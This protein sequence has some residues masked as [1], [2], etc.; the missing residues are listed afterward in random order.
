[1][2]GAHIDIYPT[3]L[4]LFAKDKI[5]YFGKDLLNAKEKN[6][7]LKDGSYSDGKY[8]YVQKNKKWYNYLNGEEIESNKEL[9]F[10]VKNTIEKKQNDLL[11]SDE[12]IKNNLIEYINGN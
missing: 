4:N 2:P 11:M 9:D 12:I 5:C 6:V 10:V 8:I 7:I 1:M 3:L